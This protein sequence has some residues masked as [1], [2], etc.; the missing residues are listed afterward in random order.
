MESYLSALITRWTDLGL[1]GF[2]DEAV[3]LIRS[4]RK[5]GNV[6][7]EAVR[8]MDPV[9]G[10]LAERTSVHGA[11]RWVKH[12]RQTLE[13]CAQLLSILENPMV[14]QGALVKLTGIEPASRLAQAE[15]ARNGPNSKAIPA[16]TNKLL[17]RMQRGQT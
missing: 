13:H 3:G 6:K 15:E 17:E 9:S 1:A 8:T 14:E 5:P 11:S 10:P 16:K 2:S 7:G 12:H 4:R